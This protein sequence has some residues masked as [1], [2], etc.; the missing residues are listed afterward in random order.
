MTLL[1]SFDWHFIWKHIPDFWDGLK[2]TLKVAGID[3]A[4]EECSIPLSERGVQAVEGPTVLGQR[5][6][7]LLPVLQ[8]DVD[9]HRRVGACH[10]G[11]VAERTSR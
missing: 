9:P 11:Q 5:R 3:P 6:S 8:E 7:N 1:A 10:A 4:R 2:Q